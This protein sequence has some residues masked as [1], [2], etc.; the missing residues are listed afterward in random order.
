MNKLTIT[1]IKSRAHICDVWHALGGGKLQHGRGKAF[2]RDGDGYCIAIDID[3]GLW[4]D[5]RDGVGGDVVTLVETVHRC[6]FVDAAKWLADQTGVALEHFEHRP[7]AAMDDDW[8]TDLRR[9]TYWRTTAVML[10]EQALASL[11]DDHPERYGLTLLL[12]SV[13]DGDASLVATYRAW[14]RREPAMTKAM[15]HA[16]RLHDARV[17]RRVARWLKEGRSD[18]TQAA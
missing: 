17:Q 18:G 8:T 13:R 1:E 10:S 7:Y 11:P 4:F 16:G 12:A 6:S 15:V 3:K 9:A 2:W 5:H 14:R